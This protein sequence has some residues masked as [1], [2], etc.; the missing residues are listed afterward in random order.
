M[1]KTDKTEL[2]IGLIGDTHIPSRAPEIPKNIISDFQDKK[3]DYLIHLGDFTELNVLNDLQETF[4]KD[5]VIG[6]LGNM[7]NSKFQG[8]LPETLD[9][10]LFGHK[11]F[12]THGTGGPN[13]IIKRLNKIHDLT[14]YDIIIFGHVHR[15][16]NERWRD[17]KLYLC[18]GTPTDT[19]FTDINSYGFLRISKEKIEPEIIYM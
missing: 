2:L 17:G 8:V 14:T 9:F 10:D 13:I 7:D 12:I 19:V 5:K 15:P 4:G 6:I 16:Y 11:I 3:I 18:P 1:I